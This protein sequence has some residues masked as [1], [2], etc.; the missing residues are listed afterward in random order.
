MGGATTTGGVTVTLPPAGVGDGVPAE[1][2]RAS[3]R[4]LVVV[5]L[6]AVDLELTGV[7]VRASIRDL[8]DLTNRG[9]NALRYHLRA[10]AKDGHVEAVEGYAADPDAPRY[11][12]LWYSIGDL[13]NF[14]WSSPYFKGL[15]AALLTPSDSGTRRPLPE[16]VP[17][18]HL[19]AVRYL[20]DCRAREDRCR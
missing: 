4:D 9:R 15:E 10:L 8:A 13:D 6:I 7:K 3:T 14:A 19:R 5:A 18:L 16:P 1:W 2:Q 11:L 17:R 12:Q 20:L